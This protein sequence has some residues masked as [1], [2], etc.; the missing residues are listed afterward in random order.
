VHGG[1]ACG[2]LFRVDWD[3]TLRPRVELRI[4]SG[5]VRAQSAGVGDDL[6]SVQGRAQ[7]IGENYAEAIAF[8][9][10]QD[11]WARTLVGPEHDVPGEPP[12]IGC[13]YIERNWLWGARPQDGIAGLDHVAAKRI[14]QTGWIERSVSIVEVDLFQRCD[15]RRHG[16]ISS[17][18]RRGWRASLPPFRCR[19]GRN[20]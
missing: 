15:F 14:K 3:G 20:S 17:A 8:I 11:Q 7:Q 2:R 13:I 9:D 5:P 6:L 18:G 4:F 16:V 10:P 19:G 1:V 12:V